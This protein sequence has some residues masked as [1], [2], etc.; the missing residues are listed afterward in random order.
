MRAIGGIWWEEACVFDGA[1]VVGVEGGDL[2]RV[3]IVVISFVW[4]RV[5]FSISNERIE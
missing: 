3:L 5:L 2:S 1:G 4:V